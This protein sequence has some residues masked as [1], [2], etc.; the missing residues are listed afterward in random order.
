VST[1]PN[2]LFGR[3]S[4][5][6][7]GSPSPRGHRWLQLF[8]I[9]VV[10]L[11]V[12]IA[13]LSWYASTPQFANKVRNKLITVLEDSTGGRVELGAFRWRVL[14]LEFEADNLTIHGLEGPGEIPYAH[15]DK[16]L[17]RVKIISLF[18]AKIGLNYLEIDK[19]VVHL[20][21]NKDG[22]T[23]QPVPK[24]KSNLQPASHSI[25]SRRERSAGRC[26]LR[27]EV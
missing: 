16:L 17:V 24:K 7:G 2:T 1:T 27:A 22:S 6:S 5:T 9:V 14:H 10:V 18:R 26:E 4:M 8:V 25:C 19:P 11:A 15:L 3:R 21:V 12:V 20:I 23:N 13:G